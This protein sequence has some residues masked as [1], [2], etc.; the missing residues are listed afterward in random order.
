MSE[1]IDVNIV[2]NDLLRNISEK[3]NIKYE[4]LLSEFSKI[5]KR[6]ISRSKYY[7]NHLFFSQVNEKSLYWAGFI[8]ADGCVFKRNNNKTLIISLSERDVCHLDK[9]KN[10][11]EFDGPL[12]KSITKHSVS[13]SKWND[14]IKRSICISSA[15]IFNDLQT[16]NICPNKTKIY[17]FPEWLQNHPLVNHFMRG[18]VD[19]DGSYFLDKSRD[20]ICFELRGTKEFLDVYKSILDQNIKITNS[21]K[22]TTP[23]STS[24]IKYYGNNTVASLYEFLYKDATVY[25]DRKKN[26]AEMAKKFLTNKK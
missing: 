3:F 10:D 1:L 15:R 19:G 8:A 24:K 20:R 5:T 26:I 18:Y 14:S 12:A 16:Y 23:D 2:E 9:L 25:L 22:V 4:E 11:I 7:C 17:T 6:R 21:N 13:N